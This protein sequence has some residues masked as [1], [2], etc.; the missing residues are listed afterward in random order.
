MHIAICLEQ[1]VLELGPLITPAFGHIFW[2]KRIQRLF[3]F[4][5]KLPKVRV[6]SVFN[7]V[8]EIANCGHRMKY[9]QLLLCV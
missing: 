5:I 4:F 9:C 1:L 7:R 8:I 6:H 2:G 3:S